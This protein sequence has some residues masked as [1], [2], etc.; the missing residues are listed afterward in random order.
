MAWYGR[1]VR[2]ITGGRRVQDHVR[3]GTASLSRHSVHA[4]GAQVALRGLLPPVHELTSSVGGWW[5]RVLRTPAA[6]AVAQAPR[7]ALRVLVVV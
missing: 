6:V 1:S 4:Y 3:I 7:Q 5:D 2:M